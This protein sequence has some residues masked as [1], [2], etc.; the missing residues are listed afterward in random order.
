MKKEDLPEK[1]PFFPISN[2][3][4]FPKTTVPLNIFEPQY[5][6]MIICSKDA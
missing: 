3:I 5:I 4:F 2:F 6:D 1:I